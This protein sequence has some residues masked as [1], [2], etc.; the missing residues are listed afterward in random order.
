MRPRGPQRLVEAHHVGVEVLALGEYPLAERA[1]LAV[2][3]RLVTVRDDDHRRA[4]VLDVGPGEPRRHR[5][6][7]DARLGLQLMGPPDDRLERL[8]PGE[9]PGHPELRK[10]GPAH[11]WPNLAAQCAHDQVGGLAP[12][13]GQVG[14]REVVARD[15]DVGVRNHL[16]RDVAVQVERHKDRPVGSHDLPDGFE[17]VPLAVLDALRDHR[18]VQIEEPA[19]DGHGRLQVLDELTLEAAPGRRLDRRRRLRCGP[20]QPHE[21]E[22]VLLGAFEI[23]GRLAVGSAVRL[24]DFLAAHDAE[25][26]PTANDS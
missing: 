2:G 17:Q 20:Q 23:A 26:D 9:L 14:M 24:Q 12:A 6:R 11:R 4:R 18:A 8:Q 1:R 3:Q 13:L 19:V 7:E 21:L 25:G 10:L 16:R 5:S 15:D 22:P